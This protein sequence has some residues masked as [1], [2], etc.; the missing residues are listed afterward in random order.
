[1]K[2]V[3]PALSRRRSHPAGSS[4]C[5]PHSTLTLTPSHTR[6][7]A[8]THTPSLSRNHCRRTTS[9][10]RGSRTR[11]ERGERGMRGQGG[12]RNLVGAGGEEGELAL[13]GADCLP[14]LHQPVLP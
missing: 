6:A 1:M 7:R 14:C 10:S 8:H 12:G 11:E 13:E 5:S 4:A 2:K 3:R 9:E